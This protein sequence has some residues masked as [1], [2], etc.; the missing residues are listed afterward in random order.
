MNLLKKVLLLFLTFSYIYSVAYAPLRFSSQV[1][2]G[3]FGIILYIIN[4]RLEKTFT[5][6]F[7]SHLPTLLALVMVTM[8]SITLNGTSDYYYITWVIIAIMQLFGA[9]F[10]M[11]IFHFFDEDYSFNSI[12]LYFTMSAILQSIISVA[13]YFS[14]SIME[15]CLSLLASSD[16]FLDTLDRTVGFRLIGFGASYFGVAVIQGFILMIMGVYIANNKMSIFKQFLLSLAYVIITVVGMMLAR[17]SMVGAFLGVLIILMVNSKSVFSIILK[18]FKIIFIVSLILTVLLLAISKLSSDAKDMLEVIY[19]FAFELFINIFE[20]ETVSTSSTDNLLRMWTIV[21]E[22]FSTWF[23][24]DGFWNTPDGRYYMGTDVGVL[25][26]IYY[27]GLIGSFVYYYYCYRSIYLLNEKS[28]PFFSKRICFFILLYCMILNLK[29]DVCL[30]N[31]CAPFYF[32]NQKKF[33]YV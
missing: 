29:G 20:S 24:G 19:K 26:N 33:C 22:N 28:H 18:L 10:L 25:R 16:G 12:S 6:Q 4:L 30:M 23:L 32:C 7:Y 3:V 5:S 21:P 8:C 13:M 9:Y 31:L 1:I 27:I 14:P 15:F 11:K 2:M 17:T